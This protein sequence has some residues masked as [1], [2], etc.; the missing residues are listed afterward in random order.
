[1]RAAERC[2]NLPPPRRKGEVVRRVWIVVCC[3]C[4]AL[5]LCARAGAAVSFGI[6]EDTGA[7]SDP[8]LFYSTL[9]DLG[10][11]EN[12]I[13]ISWDPGQPT[14]IPNQPALDVWVPQ[15]AIS[16]IQIVFAVS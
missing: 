3:A 9:T 16:G 14:T 10:A 12:R 5:G 13:A 4:V 11:T 8:T 2:A 7:L 6:T 15:A 1:M